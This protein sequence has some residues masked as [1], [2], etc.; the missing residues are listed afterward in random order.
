[1][2]EIE[3]VERYTAYLKEKGVEFC[4][5]GFPKFKP[6]WIIKTSPKLMAPFNKRQYFWQNK[7]DISICYF[8]KD[9]HLYPRLDKVFE[10]INILKK[11]HSVCMMD[12]SISP[13]MLDEVQRMNLLLNLL[14]ICIIA[15]N[16]IRIIP[17]F[18]TG[19]FE[20][21]K[22][23]IQSIGHSDYWVM[24]AIG[25]Q[26]IRN[27]SF[28]E[29]LFRTKCMFVMPLHLLCYGR[30]NKQTIK[31]LNEYG[32]ECKFYKDFRDLSYS[33]EINKYE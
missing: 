4:E 8:C 23:L 32:I 20:T 9:E 25:T 16:D 15:V 26:Q 21:L 6:E 27:N 22:L 33:S 5:N 3:L 24:G 17:S 31:C 29:Y 19:N 7:Q 12:I 10:E 11:Y 30:P 28:Y 2:H 18:R 14:F 1:M 13:L